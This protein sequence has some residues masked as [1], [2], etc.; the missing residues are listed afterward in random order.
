MS[1]LI[2]ISENENRPS[3]SETA[4]CELYSSVSVEDD[5]ERNTGET[6]TPK[7][8]FHNTVIR[9]LRPCK[10][11]VKFPNIIHTPLLHTPGKATSLGTLA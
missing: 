6:F 9:N 1:T 3:C 4:K 7:R 2:A 5:D 10:V 8:R 11:A